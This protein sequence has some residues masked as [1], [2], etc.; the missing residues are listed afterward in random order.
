MPLNPGALN[1]SGNYI[2]PD[3]LAKYIEDA[4]PPPGPLPSDPSDPAYYLTEK[5][6]FLIGFAT[7]II[8][9]L[10]AHDGDSFEITIS[11][12]SLGATAALE[13]E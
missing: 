10:K 3:C 9:Y 1:P 11:P 6:R 13:I 8:N 2:D 7:G 4:L 12:N 5:R